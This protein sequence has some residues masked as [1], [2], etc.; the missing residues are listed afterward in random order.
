LK[1]P[2][3]AAPPREHRESPD[4]IPLAD[5]T[6]PAPAATPPNTSEP[7]EPVALPD[8]IGLVDV[9]AAPESGSPAI[10][11][12]TWQE[13]EGRWDAIEI[14]E[15]TVDTQRIKLEGLRTE[16][17]ANLK[18]T[19]TVEEKR[20]ALGADVARWTKA[21]T[22]V[23]HAVPKAREFIHRATWA[24]GTPER[25]RLQELFENETRPNIPVAQADKLRDEL[26][27]LLKDRQVLSAHGVLVTQECENISRDIQT[28]LKTLQSNAADRARRDARAAR[29]QG[30]FF[31][32]VRRLSGA[33]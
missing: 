3:P 29:E 16:M 5:D 25:K 4:V 13:L 26:E 8:D 32:D 20:H 7:A 10:P 15:A 30:K 12:A 11:E 24:M 19:L 9:V 27:N 22:R 14:Q 21:K 28:A 6:E 1:P 31:K 23:H 2:P 17:E 18:A 33:D